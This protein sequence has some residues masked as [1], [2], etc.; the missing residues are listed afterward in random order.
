[1]YNMT[2]F[3]AFWVRDYRDRVRVKLQKRKKSHLTDISMNLLYIE[4]I[5]SMLMDGAPTKSLDQIII[6]SFE[7]SLNV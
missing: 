5:E 4:T 2:P 6:K 1:M 3:D 7:K